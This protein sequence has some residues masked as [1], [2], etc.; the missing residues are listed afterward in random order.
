MAYLKDEKIRR[1]G[2]VRI[3]GRPLKDV[4]TAA[5]MDRNFIAQ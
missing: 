5:K 3:A 2:F 1:D 4:L